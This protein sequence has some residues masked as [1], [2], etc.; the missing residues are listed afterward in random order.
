[1]DGSRAV[2]GTR[3]DHLTLDE[4]E[5]PSMWRRPSVITWCVL[6]WTLLF[7]YESLRANYLTPLFH[8]QLPKLPLLFPPAGWIMFFNIDQRYGFIEVY[9]LRDGQPILLDPHEMFS[10][11]AVGY[12]NIHRNALVGVMGRNRAE[13]F[14]RYLRRKFPEHREFAVIEAEYPDIVRTPDRIVRHVAY[15]CQ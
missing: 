4:A 10:T 14:C 9:G 3:N 5:S 11:K 1:M 12:D 13:P 15:R 8:H 7:H 2:D 6:C